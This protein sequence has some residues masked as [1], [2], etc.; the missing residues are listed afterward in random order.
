M[1]LLGT[2]IA[3]VVAAVLQEGMGFYPDLL[4]L[5]MGD[6]VMASDASIWLKPGILVT[7]AVR[8]RRV[9]NSSTSLI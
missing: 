4:T 6:E 3:V 8:S 1:S 5:V 9:C 7:I 2:L